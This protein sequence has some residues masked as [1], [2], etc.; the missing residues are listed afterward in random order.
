MK[1]RVG[2]LLNKPN[3]V[4]KI[5][6]SEVNYNTDRNKCYINHSRSRFVFG[7]KIVHFGREFSDTIADKMPI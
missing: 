3:T 4:A 2:T 1:F 5:K 7:L 6:S